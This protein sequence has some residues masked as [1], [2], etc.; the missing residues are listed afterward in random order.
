MVVVMKR[1]ATD[2]DIETVAEKAR[3]AGG[4]AFV[5]RGAV[6]TVVGLVGDTERLRAA[7]WRQ[8]HGVEL[9]R[10]VD[11]RRHRCCGDRRHPELR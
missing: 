9:E 10:R 8:L 1:D 6:H 4:E 2:A 7:D 11:D 3:G 5:S